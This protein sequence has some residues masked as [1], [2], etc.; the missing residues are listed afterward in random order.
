MGL[1]KKCRWRV[2]QR[3]KS[4]RMSGGK[5]SLHSWLDRITMVGKVMVRTVGMKEK[6]L[7]GAGSAGSERMITLSALVKAIRGACRR[8]SRSNPGRVPLRLKVLLAALLL[9]SA[10]AA[11]HQV[12]TW[13]FERQLHRIAEGIVTETN[14]SGDNV[15]RVESAGTETT[16]EVFASQKYLLFGPVTG[17]IVFLITPLCNDE[18]STDQTRLA[19]AICSGY[20]THELDY[21]YVR[22]KDGWVF[23]ESYM[24]RASHTH[25]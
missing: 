1:S 16:C 11:R 4:S 8:I 22:G 13:R 12:R 23:Q 2:W 14:A 6:G 19:C 7:A 18:H 5:I 10:G 24:E 21:V 3:P 25:R 17:K 20:A 9:V 15:P